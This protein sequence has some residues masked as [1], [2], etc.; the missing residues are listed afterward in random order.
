MCTHSMKNTNSCTSV[1]V[2]QNNVSSVAPYYYLHYHSMN[3]TH[4]ILSSAWSSPVRD[5]HAKYKKCTDLA[6]C[7]SQAM[8]LFPPPW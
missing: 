2:G 5:I 3:H 6:R 4:V 8:S 1:F 7:V